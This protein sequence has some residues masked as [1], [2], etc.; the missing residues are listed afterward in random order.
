MTYR[1]DSFSQAAALPTLAE[2]NRS[3]PPYED[4]TSLPAGVRCTACASAGIPVEMRIGLVDAVYSEEY[5]AVACP[6]CLMSGHRRCTPGEYEVWMRMREE[7]ARD[8]ED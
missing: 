8:D 3:A 1:D 4:K 6:R 5:V 7:L 2:L